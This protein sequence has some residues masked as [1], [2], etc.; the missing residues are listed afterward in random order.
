MA[1]TVMTYCHDCS[2]IQEW[3]EPSWGSGA[4]EDGV[5]DI[6]TSTHTKERGTHLVSRACPKSRQDETVQT[7][8]LTV[9]STEL[10]VGP[11][12]TLL[13][14]CKVDS[15]GALREGVRV[16]IRICLFLPP[17]L[18]PHPLWSTRGKR[19]LNRLL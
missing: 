10:F 16:G 2:L 1:A 19:G 8:T 7:L 11:L 13:P 15:L 12:P 5:C 18:P 3:L 14:S 4:E 9:F 6:D 17:E